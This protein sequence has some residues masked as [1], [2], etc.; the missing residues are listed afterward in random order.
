MR[1]F[2]SVTDGQ[3]VQQTS[4]LLFLKFIFLKNWKKKKK[5]ILYVFL[6]K[7]VGL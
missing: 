1:I 4:K 2:Y 6:V 5:N 7:S 3:I